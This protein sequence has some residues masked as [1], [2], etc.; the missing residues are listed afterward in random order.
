MSAAAVLAKQF[1]LNQQ[2]TELNLEG[3]GH[4]ASLRSPQ[5][6]G[7]CINWIL[8]HMV[9]TR[10]AAFELLGAEPV[11]GETEARRY[12]RGSPPIR[13]DGEALRLERLQADL[14][15]SQTRLVPLLE[16]LSA[17]ALSRPSGEGERT[18]GDQLV[19]LAFHESY[20][21]GQIGLMRRVVGLR[22]AIP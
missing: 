8:G 18:V 21:A 13:G 15:A 6:D 11:W 5:P 2:V 14:A 9:A 4:A 10:N 12:R 22:G 19:K 1:T 16:G 7:N 3:V 17:D 20:H